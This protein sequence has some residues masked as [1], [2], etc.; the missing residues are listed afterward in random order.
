[1]NTCVN[2]HNKREVTPETLS[3]RHRSASEENR[4]EVSKGMP[5]VSP[6]YGTEHTGT[7][8]PSPTATDHTAMET[9]VS[10]GSTPAKYAREHVHVQGVD[11]EKK[12]GEFLV[13]HNK[14]FKGLGNIP[15]LGSTYTN[16]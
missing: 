7:A 12:K 6:L 3:T 9:H 8:A 13:N 1:M 16:D 5:N 2:T 14:N 4:Q 10:R 11:H 15:V